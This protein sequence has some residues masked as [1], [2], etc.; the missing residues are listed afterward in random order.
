[1]NHEQKLKVEKHRQ[2]IWAETQEK[3][4]NRKSRYYKFRRFLRFD[5]D[6]ERNLRTPHKSEIFHFDVFRKNSN[7]HKALV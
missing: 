1:M 4:N 6:R 2:K 5:N 3:I 7:H